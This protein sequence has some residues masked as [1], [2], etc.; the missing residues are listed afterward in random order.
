M[1]GIQSL[2]EVIRRAHGDWDLRTD[3]HTQPT[4]TQAYLRHPRSILQPRALGGILIA[5]GVRCRHRFV[6]CPCLFIS[7][8]SPLSP[9]SVPLVRC[10]CVNLQ[11]ETSATDRRHSALLDPRR[12]M[13]WPSR[14]HV[15][16]T[17]AIAASL[18]AHL[19]RHANTAVDRAEVDNPLSPFAGSDS[20]PL[21][22]FMLSTSMSGHAITAEA[23]SQSMWPGKQVESPHGRGPRRM[24]GPAYTPGPL[25]KPKSRKRWS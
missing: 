7:H 25:Y 11:A 16:R 17:T 24:R 3:Q 23:R 22:G 5:L 18:S 12:E 9:F 6:G 21:F 2:S 14:G 8:S 19:G 13:R 15:T 20:L 4:P 1:K 10:Y